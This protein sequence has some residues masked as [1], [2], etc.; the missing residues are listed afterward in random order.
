MYEQS[1][2]TYVFNIETKTH[3]P[4]ETDFV[5]SL[6]IFNSFIDGIWLND[7]KW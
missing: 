4:F 1:L 5:C 3:D 2:K 6:W 7:E